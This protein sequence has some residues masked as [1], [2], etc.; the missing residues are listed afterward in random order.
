M[1]NLIAEIEN[2][3]IDLPRRRTIRIDAE[4]LDVLQKLINELAISESSLTQYS[5]SS[6][7]EIATPRFEESL[8]R[9]SKI[10]KELQVIIASI[11]MVPLSEIFAEMP[12]MVRDLALKAGKRVELQVIGGE[13][14]MKRTVLMAIFNPMI[15]LIRNCID[16]GI[17]TPHE[18]VIA[19]KSAEGS[20]ILEAC[21]HHDNISIAVSDD[22]RG[23]D[24]E[25]ILQTAREKC[26]IRG[27]G[28]NLTYEE[29]WS[30]ILKPGFSTA[31]KITELSGCGIGMDIVRRGMEIIG[32]NIKITSEKGRGTRFTLLIPKQL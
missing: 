1:K 7:D 27:D 11:R 20:I 5:E 19:G 22:G 29:T 23:M 9:L 24:R 18:R 28:Q 3:D 25:K 12:R 17:E 32:G 26:S 13:I 31:G 21:N 8:H 4:K 30:L 10:T 15:Q 14:N 16:H 2:S 6:N